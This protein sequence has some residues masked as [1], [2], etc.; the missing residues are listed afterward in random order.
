MNYSICLLDVGG[1]TQRT[2][3]GPFDND[4]AALAQA[5][6]EVA[7]SPIVEIWKDYHLIARLYR[8]PPSEVIQ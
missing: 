4:T 7:G 1:R 8:E 6:T 2:T 5:R 3:Y